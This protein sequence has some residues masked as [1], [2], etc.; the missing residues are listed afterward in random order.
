MAS[1]MHSRG[2]KTGVVVW[3]YSNSGSIEEPDM[4]THPIVNL[5]LLLRVQPSRLS[6]KEFTFTARASRINYSSNGI[7]MRFAAEGS[8]V[9]KVIL[10]GMQYKLY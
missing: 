5:S 4:S 6:C 10:L 2:I 3:G 1:D 8:I 7:D 9:S